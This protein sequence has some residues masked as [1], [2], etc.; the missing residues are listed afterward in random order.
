VVDDDTNILFAFHS[1]LDKEGYVC[2]EANTAVQAFKKFTQEKPQ[3]VFLDISLH[4]SDGIKVLRKIREENN[5]TPVIIMSSFENK[6]IIARAF[7]AGAFEY[8]KKPISI[9]KIRQTLIKAVY[10]SDLAFITKSIKK[11]VKIEY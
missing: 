6:K 8:I 2:I 1:L 9:T 4:S 3:A 11:G 7:Q 5:I 10:G